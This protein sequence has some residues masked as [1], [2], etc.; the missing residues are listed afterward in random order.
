MDKLDYLNIGNIDQVSK[1]VVLL[2]QDIIRRNGQPIEIDIDI[3]MNYNQHESNVS[4]YF[5]SSTEILESIIDKIEI[6]EEYLTKI[7]SS[8]LGNNLQAIILYDII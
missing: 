7:K 4:G 1:D 6:L 3:D 8:R 2:W 5:D